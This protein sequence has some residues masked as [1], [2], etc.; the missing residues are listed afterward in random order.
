MAD[1]QKITATR[2]A[3]DDVTP[4]VP[5]KVRRVTYERKFIENQIKATTA[6]RDALI[7]MKEAELKKYTDILAEMDKLGI[8]AEIKP[9][10]K[11]NE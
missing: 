3:I 8:V 6:Q 9:E 4:A 11:P 7:A 2:I 5:E 1:A 10:E